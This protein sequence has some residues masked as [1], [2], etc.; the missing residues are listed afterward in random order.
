VLVFEADDA[1]TSIKK[2][3]KSLFNS[4]DWKNMHLLTYFILPVDV[5]LKGKLLY[6]LSDPS[7]ITKSNPVFSRRGTTSAD[8]IWF[9]LEWEQYSS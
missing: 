5:H 4:S 9:Y 6:S 1:E 8:L 2:I 3:W 7:Q